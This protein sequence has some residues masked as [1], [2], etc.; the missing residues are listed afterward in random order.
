LGPGLMLRLF[1]PAMLGAYADGA[2]PSII[3][4]LVP[5][6]CGRGCIPPPIIML[7]GV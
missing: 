5:G 4:P 7:P 6:V 3:M 1:M 2:P